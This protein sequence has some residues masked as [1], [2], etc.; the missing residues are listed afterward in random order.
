SNAGTTVNSSGRT[1]TDITPVT[2]TTTIT[3]AIV[4]TNDSSLGNCNVTDEDGDTLIFHYR[5]FINNTINETGSRSGQLES[6][7]INVN[8]LSSAFYVKTDVLIFEC[9]ADDGNTNS[10][11]INSSSKTVSNYI[12]T[13]ENVSI[14][15]STA[16]TNSS[17][18]GTGDFR[19]D[20]GDSESGSTYRWFVNNTIIAGQVAITLNNTQFAKTDTIIF[21]YTPK[22][23]VD[24]GTSVNAS[25]VTVLNYLPSVSNVNITPTTAYT[26]TNLTGAGT[27]YDLD[28]DSSS[29]TYKWYV[30]NTVISGQVLTTLNDTSY[31]KTDTLIFEYI[32]NDGTGAGTLVNSSG[33][34][35]LDSVVT[36]SNTDIGSL[37]SYTNDT[38]QVNVTS[39]NDD[40]GG[41][42][43]NVVVEWFKNVASWFV[44]AF[45]GKSSGYVV[46]AN[47]TS[48]NF[49]KDDNITAEINV[50]SQKVNATPV[51]TTVLMISDITPVT[52]T[53]TITPAT[54]YTNTTVLGNCNVTDEDND[55][56]TYHYKWFINNTLNDTGSRVSQ[57]EGEVI[58]VANMSSSYTA[59][60]DVILFECVA[61]DS[62]ENS[63][64]TNSSSKT[65]SSYTPITAISTITPATA[66]TNDTILGS[67]NVTDIDGESLTY[68]YRWFINNTLNDTGSR[69]SQLEGEVINVAN[70]SSTYTAK[71]DVLLFE[72]RADDGV[73]NSTRTNSSSKTISNY[74]PSVTNVNI[75]PSST[76][77]TVNLTG[78]GTYYDLDGDSSSSTYKW[79]V[80]N[81]AIGG[82]VSVTLNST[83]FAHTDVIIFE[84]NPNDGTGDGTSVN[85]SGVTIVNTVPVASS[86][87]INPIVAYINESLNCT[88]TF[89]DDDSDSDSGTVFKWFK[90]NTEVVYGSECYQETA[91]TGTSCGGLKGGVYK[92]EG[93]WYDG[94]GYDC[95]NTYDGSWTTF[96]YAYPT[97]P[98]SGNISINYTKPAN[99]ISTSMWKMKYHSDGITSSF[100]FNQSCWD[101]YDDKLVLKVMSIDVGSGIDEIH[102]FCYN[103]S[104]WVEIFMVD[105]SSGG[106][107]YEEAM[108]WNLSANSTLTTDY[109]GGDDNMICEVTPADGTAG[110]SV[111]SSVTQVLIVPP[112]IQTVTIA[113]TVA[114]MNDTLLGNCNA[115]SDDDNLNFHY[116]WFINNT[117]N[118]TGSRLSQ[119]SGEVINVANMSSKYHNRTD[120][121]IFECRADDN[122]SNS[123]KTNSSVLTI[124]NYDPVIATVTI[125]PSTVYTNDTALGNCNAT[126]VNNANLN[127]HYRW[128]INNT[129]NE[130]GSKLS[131]SEGEVHNIANL[132]SSYY[133]RT[134]VLLFECV[135]DDGFSN[136]TRTNS[137]IKTIS[138]YLPTHDTPVVNTTSL[139]NGTSENIT[140]WYQNVADSEGDDVK[141]ITVWQETGK[142][143]ILSCPFEGGSNST[144]TRDYSLEGINST[145]AD[146]TWDSSGGYDGK[147]AYYFDGADDAIIYEESG[148]HIQDTQGSISVW[149]NATSGTNEV[150]FVYRVKDA[151]AANWFQL[152]VVNSKVQLKIN[153]SGTYNSVTSP[154][155]VSLN[156]WHHVVVLSNGG[157]Y[158]M[159]LDGVNI[160]TT[161]I[162]QLANGVWLDA[163]T[164]ANIFGFGANIISPSNIIAEFSG[165]I[166]DFQMYNYSLSP[167]QISALYNN[168]TDVVSSQMTSNEDNWTVYVTPNDGVS[169]GV[170]KS[171]NILIGGLPNVSN[172][173]ITPSS[174]NITSNL[175]GNGTY[176]GGGDGGESG[177]TFKWFVNN[178]VIAGQV[179]RTLN[180]TQFAKTDTLI[181]EYT[182]SD[183]SSFGVSVNSSGVTISN[184]LPLSS[185]P[186]W[187]TTTGA[188]SGVRTYGQTI[189][190]INSTCTDEDGGEPN[191][192]T[193]TV[194]KPG[195]TYPVNDV[196]MTNVSDSYTY[197]SDI[198]LDEAGT[199]TINTTVNDGD[200]THTNS[201][202]ITVETNNV[203]TVDGYY[204]FTNDGILSEASI[205][206]TS[207]T[208]EYDLYELTDNL[209]TYNANW[210]TLKSRINYS[211]SLNLVVGLNLIMDANCTNAGAINAHEAT[212]NTNLDDLL[213]GT[214]RTATVYV[215]LEFLN[216]SYSNGTD[217]DNC[218]NDLAGAVTNA[219]DNQFVVYAKGYNSSGLDRAYLQ[220]SIVHYNEETTQA[221]FIN[222]EADTVRTTAHLNRVY[223]LNLHN[224]TLLLIGKD[225]QDKAY[226]V[227]R[228]TINSSTSLASK[229]TG[230]LDNADVLVF[231]NGSSAFTDE[232]FTI[233]SG[234]GK[235]IYDDTNERILEMDTDLTI[236]ADVGAYSVA[237]LQ[238]DD[239][240]H[241]QL[242][243]KI[244]DGTL[245]KATSSGAENFSWHDGSSDGANQVTSTT[246]RRFY[247]Y[248]SKFTTSNTYLN[249]YGWLNSSNIQNW[250]AY[251]HIVI[252]DKN[253]GEI[254][255]IIDQTDVYGYI[256]VN[257]FNESNA[258]WLADKKALFDVWDDL[259]E[260]IEGVFVD[261]LDAATIVNDTDFEIKFKS[262]I[263]YIK[264][265]NSKKALLNT[266]TY[267]EEYA[268]WGD[269]VYKESC[270]GRW[271]GTNATAPTLYD[272]ETWS[273][274]LEKAEFFQNHNV[275]VYCVA[276][277]NYTGAVPRQVWNY[278][279]MVDMFYASKVLGYD[280]FSLG[281]PDFLYAVDLYVP[282]VGT[283]LANTWSTSD[284]ETY[285]RAY[286]N[287]VVYYNTSSHDGWQDDGREFESVVLYGNFHDDAASQA[288]EIYL[289]DGLST[290]VLYNYSTAGSGW[291]YNW[292]NISLNASEYYPDGR[293]E[294]T[295]AGATAIA[296]LS[297]DTSGKANQGLRTWFSTNKGSTW[298]AETANYLYMFN[299]QVNNSRK[300]S[301]D[302]FGRLNQTAINKSGRINITLAGS[303]DFN[304]TV[305][306]YPVSIEFNHTFYNATYWNGS[307]WFLLDPKL[308]TACDSDN[309]SWNSTSVG[310]EN[311]LSC[312]EQSGV[313]YTFRFAPPKMSTRLFGAEG[314]NKPVFVNSKPIGDKNFSH[315]TNLSVKLNVSDPDNDTLTYSC[316]ESLVTINSDGLI[317]DNPVVGDVGSLNV[318]CNVSDGGYVLNTSFR[319]SIV[320]NPPRIV[321]VNII[322]AT[323]YTNSSLN[324][325]GTYSD[326]ES[327]AQSGSTYRWF[328]NN[329]IIAGQVAITLN[330]TQFA[331]TDTI[332][333][334]YK[335]KDGT[336][337]GTARNSSGRAISNYAP[338]F[339]FT[340]ITPTTA[341][342]ND[343]LSVTATV[344]DIDG[345]TMNIVIEWFKN[346]A[347]WFVKTFTGKSNNY[348]A[349]SNL[350]SANFSK[351]DNLTAEINVGDGSENATPRNTST[352]MISNNAPVM[353]TNTITPSTVPTNTSA[354]GSCNS[355]DID[356]DTLQFF[357]K[358]Y[359]NNTINETGSR[360]GQSQGEVINVNNLS[361][362]YYAETDVLIFECV[363]DDSSVNGTKLNSSGK[364][365][366]NSVPEF[367]AVII[368]PAT[369]Y[370]N[371]TALGKCDVSDNDG[372]NLNFHYRWFINNTLNETGSKLS[373]TEGE[374]LNIAN[375]SSSF[376]AKTDVLLFECVAD[377]NTTNS[378]RTNSSS[379]TISNYLPSVSNVNITPTTAYTKTNLTGAGTY[380]DIDS[381]ASSS[382]YKWYVNNTVISGQILTT[383]NDTSYAK[384]DTLIFEFT[385]NDGTGAGTPVNSS[386]VTILDSIVTYDFTNLTPTTAY[387]NDTLQVNVTAI[388]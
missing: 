14:T 149:F 334:E 268:T 29:S 222:W 63:T 35:I 387:T 25:G 349:I 82:Q 198:Y 170:T 26:K 70:I 115:T 272:W 205:L 15:P 348:V 202:T 220:D 140:V 120:A 324:G 133:V 219:T 72:C 264:V 66:Y 308:S 123:T 375:L 257:D 294:V 46:S 376:Y 173:N 364:T 225:L 346:L 335:P 373:Q 145:V 207:G 19:D 71:T 48:E 233:K 221:S 89:S 327:D 180:N 362:A 357:Y 193:I 201:T 160:T 49:S 216:Q 240:D 224:T 343:T 181:F 351:D 237:Y 141:N 99:A 12:P 236:Y 385:P 159:W 45:T 132:S 323:A 77:T 266:Y 56:L 245:Y 263:D 235:D 336:D 283:D 38:L 81:T 209:T 374:L 117:L 52:I 79:F 353:R 86:V 368:T 218:F 42:T 325:T 298:T 369:V 10:T 13:V 87:T 169:D 276:F 293:Y 107:I 321:S 380:T 382:T 134:D 315:G 211:Y 32:P 247:L 388:R 65:I 36:F 203:S 162:I 354:K 371:D 360:T 227:L 178:T 90:N 361:S 339:D 187:S 270:V 260:S 50:E 101:A 242:N 282:D 59:K 208:Y 8:N 157:S 33:V 98:I 58:N 273:L 47:L 151:G 249:Y 252:D 184:S 68:H 239:F 279:R 44:Q 277:H 31:A 144:W 359:I 106:Y 1:I 80:N 40:D 21:E 109:F 330:S 232:A 340:N 253:R 195:G 254:A 11:R 166:D 6:E 156:E 16:Y 214:Y 17:L 155:T 118:D 74:L 119:S 2:I 28:G 297:L 331:V 76:N 139:G 312:Y 176:G 112:A 163:M 130:T 143:T 251:N 299:L 332:I 41:S 61:D 197:T 304:L 192:C 194:R 356:G 366:S 88:Y 384:T 250:T 355:T 186:I 22:D 213:S 7:L 314:N 18:N 39:I 301:L 311:I 85:A 379:K 164:G 161:N 285:S 338:T 126:D 127:F 256:A 199:W 318:T 111:N 30:N 158:E 142:S 190:W 291:A 290:P 300:A 55:T 96:G 78:A 284:N 188:T 281:Q 104:Q 125:T 347:S 309:P 75:T 135:A 212:I 137:S 53:T 333:F 302:T 265:D 206:S 280:Y 146:A 95:E 223:N 288:Y 377:D 94:A 271:N 196:A 303:S 274:E 204:G 27:Y 4:Y 367:V 20:D 317:Y 217:V 320:N 177:S 241:Y 319:Y 167:Q 171:A 136:G 116:K 246:Q 138:N 370:T 185:T 306:S 174:A 372:E 128:F 229:L 230:E 97:P 148:W 124:N 105:G 84:Y 102:G 108:E 121:I 244:D 329:T 182:P 60:T 215:S 278:T 210:A 248:D 261:G 165:W 337:F 131:Q 113:P 114:Y 24:F 5:W 262:L 275:D 122:T 183:G 93:T 341:Y 350:T 296:Y 328:V 54:A 51:N 200:A 57:L 23:G 295:V 179:A 43:V 234:T 73:T 383:L 37:T 307:K 100:N 286:S 352:L 363:T 238:L 129:L 34:T 258:T 313:N 342:T 175:T 172:V 62:S 292:Y 3:P 231:N 322:P 381:D 289:S 243:N 150:I 344:N 358:W 64:K 259:N 267:S 147:G 152:K 69:A 154:S 365:V 110:V 305:W 310:G 191:N 255:E 316:N 345:D 378:T 386:G 83:Q 92:C 326:N 67:C 103:S 226:K 287:G 269:G 153:P 189:D 168:K 9:L 228:S 91:T